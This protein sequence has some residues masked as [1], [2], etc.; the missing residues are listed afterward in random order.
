M[1]EDNKVTASAPGASKDNLDAGKNN[2]CNN[3][4]HVDTEIVLVWNENNAD[5]NCKTLKAKKNNLLET[6]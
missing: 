3:D 6:S 4:N 5:K 1:F 2:D